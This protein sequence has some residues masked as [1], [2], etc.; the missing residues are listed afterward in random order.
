MSLGH[1]ET[2]EA[3]N[4]LHTA[5]DKYVLPHTKWTVELLIVIMTLVGKAFN[6]T[7]YAGTITTDCITKGVITT[8]VAKFLVGAVVPRHP[9]VDIQSNFINHSTYTAKAAT[10]L[11][12]TTN[13]FHMAT[14]GL[15]DLNDNNETSAEDYFHRITMD[16]ISPLIQNLL[17]PMGLQSTHEEIT[18]CPFVVGG[19]NTR[20]LV[21]TL[22]DEMKNTILSEF[23]RYNFTDQ[24]H[25]TLVAKTCWTSRIQDTEEVIKLEIYDASKE[26]RELLGCKAGIS[27]QYLEGVILPTKKHQIELE[28]LFGLIG[29]TQQNTPTRPGMET[30]IAFDLHYG[31]CSFKV[32]LEN[33]FRGMLR[34]THVAT[35]PSGATESY[36]PV[37]AM[38]KLA[39]TIR[40][41]SGTAMNEFF[42]NLST[43]DTCKSVSSQLP[44]TIRLC[45]LL[46]QGQSLLV[47]QVIEGNHRQDSISSLS[48]A[49]K[50]TDSIGSLALHLFFEDSKVVQIIPSQGEDERIPTLQKVCSI[51]HFSISIFL[52]DSTKNIFC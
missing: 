2:V 40:S 23:P 45:K 14:K 37:Y 28:S 21:G 6:C 30:G 8:D 33:S 11:L 44:E 17:L 3:F 7:Q 20:S 42:P 10:K 9:L 32:E 36:N 5:M 38:K 50:E 15:E 48:E 1:A 43:I 34:Q 26:I 24:Y 41:N 29:K 16:G 51:A 47:D 35:E 4:K 39:T 27:G 49:I 12:V 19:F 13:K 25:T 52:G 31:Y 18:F 46:L 22:R